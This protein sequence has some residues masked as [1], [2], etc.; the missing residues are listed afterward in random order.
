MAP[1]IISLVYSYAIKRSPRVFL[2]LALEFKKNEFGDGLLLRARVARVGRADK[3][4]IAP[5]EFF[6]NHGVGIKNP[7]GDAL[8]A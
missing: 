8:T 3:G 5:N 2:I 4:S 1:I 6:L 7:R